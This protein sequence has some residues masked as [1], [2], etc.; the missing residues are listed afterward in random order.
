MTNNL[1][2]GKTKASGTDKDSD[3]SS[4]SS[5]EFL[6]P[7]FNPNGPPR[8]IEVT[9]LTPIACACTDLPET[10]LPDTNKVLR[11][12]KTPSETSAVDTRSPVFFRSSSE[13]PP[14]FTRSS[15]SR[16]KTPSR[17]TWDSTPSK[18]SSKIPSTSTKDFAYFKTPSEAPSEAGS[19]FD[20]ESTAPVNT[21]TTEESL[22]PSY[23][24]SKALP[25]VSDRE[26]LLRHIHEK[27]I[28]L[29]QLSAEFA[30][31]ARSILPIKKNQN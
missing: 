16:S 20:D 18:R 25:T 12:S 3:G 31:M 15:R 19:T 22:A 26:R 6:A 10:N 14:T 4:H 13:T 29:I 21:S 28:R 8:L 1:Q 7:T 24:A 17:S 11:S 5:S 9:P 2:N 27:Q 23:P 30:A